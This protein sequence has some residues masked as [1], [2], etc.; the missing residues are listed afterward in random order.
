MKHIVDQTGG[1]LK[2]EIKGEQAEQFLQRCA[3]IGIRMWQIRRKNKTTLECYLEMTKPDLL[4]KLLA[5]SGCRIRILE[6]KGMAY[7]WKKVKRRMGVVAGLFFFLFILLVLSNMVWSIQIKGADPK[8]E[9]QIRTILKEQHLYVGTLDFFVPDSGLLEDRLSAALTKVTWIGVSREGTSY[10]IDVVQKKYPKKK[11]AAGPRNLIAAK[12]AMIH[13]LFVEAGRPV[14]ERNQYVRKGQLLVSGRTGDDKSL[15]FVAAEGKI[16]GETWY[17]SETVIPL[18]SRYTL[19]TDS[20]YLQHRLTFWGAALPLWGLNERPYRQF[21]KETIRRPVRFLLWDLPVSYVQTRYREKKIV[22]RN[23]TEREALKEADRTATGQLL[24][25]L[26]SGA[27]I[28]SSEVISKEHVKG[29]L[30]VRS[31]HVVY[32]NIARMQSIDISAEK[33][34]MKNKGDGE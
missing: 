6:K 4:R 5:D 20:T 7:T 30:V 17:D 34:K 26:P 9:E 12:S 3:E 13:Q 16:T 24:H 1:Y 31:H 27:E 21:D 8:L 22:K 28:V 29:N 15:N 23:L 32:E 2:A 10:N 14:V 33:K 19:Y 25:R 18:S 11:K